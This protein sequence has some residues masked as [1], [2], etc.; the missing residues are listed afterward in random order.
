M[1]LISSSETPSKQRGRDHFFKPKNQMTKRITTLI[2]ICALFVSA[3]FTL[4]SSASAAKTG[5]VCKKINSKGWDGNKPIVCKKNKFGKI[6][7]TKFKSAP[8][9][10]FEAEPASEP[11]PAPAKYKLTIVL[12]EVD[13]TFGDSYLELFAPVTQA[14][15]CDLGGSKYKD[16]NAKTSVE[17]RDGSASLLATGVLGPAKVEFG[18]NGLFKSC[19]FSPVFELKKSDF[20]QIKIGTRL[21]QALTFAEL[22]NEKKWTLNLTLGI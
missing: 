7:W 21:N 12:F 8:E 16:I 13:D 19:E 9:P 11:A 10:T 15:Y 20:Y 17:I 3:E 22:E 5:S 1:T 14:E 6:V 18:S 4:M 2:V